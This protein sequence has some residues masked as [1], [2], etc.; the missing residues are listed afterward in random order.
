MLCCLAQS[1]LPQCE[2]DPPPALQLEQLA[3]QQGISLRKMQGSINKVRCSGR[4]VQHLTLK[5]TCQCQPVCPATCS[6]TAVLPG[7]TATT[8]LFPFPLFPVRH[9]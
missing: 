3:A 2:I 5:L 9:L 1:R 4:W 7:C 8:S 6:V